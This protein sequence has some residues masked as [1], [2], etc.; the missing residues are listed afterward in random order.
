M[1][2]CAFV[3]TVSTVDQQSWAHA[4]RDVRVQG[5][6]GATHDQY[7]ATVFVRGICVRNLH[8]HATQQ[9]VSTYIIVLAHSHAC[10]D[11]CVEFPGT[12]NNA[13]CACVSVAMQVLFVQSFTCSLIMCPIYCTRTFLQHAYVSPLRPDGH[14]VTYVFSH[15]N[16]RTRKYT[17]YN[18]KHCSVCAFCS[19]LA[20]PR[21]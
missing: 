4:E 18:A 15:T 9:G 11:A 8:T 10:T 12:P 5:I 20:M 16:I 3:K 19:H 6:S 13:C 1:H 21:R 7:C 2:A 17:L 14:S